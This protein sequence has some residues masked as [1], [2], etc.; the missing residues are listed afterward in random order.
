MDLNTDL[1]GPPGMTTRGV[2]TGSSVHGDNNPTLH[3]NSLTAE[4]A[5][6]NAFAWNGVADRGT[7]SA[8]EDAA[9]SKELAAGERDRFLDGCL[10]IQEDERLRLGRELHDST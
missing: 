9:C 5:N 1:P 2:D 8:F 6:D 7:G 10:K 4:Q 3:D